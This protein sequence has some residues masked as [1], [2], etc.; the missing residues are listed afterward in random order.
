MDGL[1]L[2]HWTRAVTR[3]EIE[4]EG[5]LSDVMKKHSLTYCEAL[6]CCTQMMQNILKF[7]L[8]F[9]RHPDNSDKRADEE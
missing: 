5:A 6:I 4:L 3:A 8:R 9:E 2:H 7:A 1:K